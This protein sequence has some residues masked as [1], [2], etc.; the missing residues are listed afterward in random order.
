MVLHHHDLHHGAHSRSI[1]AVIRQRYYLPRVTKLLEKASAQCFKC[2]RY[3]MEP[4][5]VKMASVPEARALMND[6]FLHVTIDTVGPF[7]V[8]DLHRISRKKAKVWALLTVCQASQLLDIELLGDASAASVCLALDNVQAR[9][10][11]IS[12]ITM[13]PATC[14]IALKYDKDEKIGEPRARNLIFDDEE[15][16]NVEFL[17][18]NTKLIKEHAKLSGF[19]LRF[20]LLRPHTI[21]D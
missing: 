9:T 7:L 14:F 18:Q 6:P 19:D 4:L 1:A 16:D 5:R 17:D 13:D 15:K 12:T 2:I 8:T 11:F 10:G 21:K 3:R 20:P